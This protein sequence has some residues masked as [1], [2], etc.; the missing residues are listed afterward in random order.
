L[1]QYDEQGFD[2]AIKLWEIL[3]ANLPG[4]IE[5]L[6]LPARMIAYFYGQKYSEMIC[7]I[8]PSKK[9]LKLAFHK[10][11]ELPDLAN[12]LEGRAKYSRYIG[13]KS[14]TQ[15]YSSALKQLIEGALV[16]H[17]ERVRKS[18]LPPDK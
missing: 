2:N 10:G 4:I 5:Q 13:I 15:I 3:I 11:V 16:A 18:E 8:I 17:K 9:G 1:S 7:T 6:D 12:L 14:D